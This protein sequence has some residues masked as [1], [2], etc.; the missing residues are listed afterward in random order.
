MFGRVVAVKST[1]NALSYNEQKLIAGRAECILAE[2]FV[3]D[4]AE[5]S[6]ED[7]LDHFMQWIS[8]N[9]RVEYNT[10][11]NSVNFG[12]EERI[13]NEQMQE[14]AKRYMEGIGFQDQPYLVYRHHDSAHPHF[15]TVST[16]IKPDGSPINIDKA[17]LH[18]SHELCRHLEKEFC[19][20]PRH[21]AGVEDEEKFRVD[22]A[23]RVVYGEKPLQRAISDVLHT[24]IDHYNYTNLA[25]L[26]A[27][28][29]LYGVKADRGRE[30]SRV[31]Q[32]RGLLYYAV[33]EDGR[34]MGK[35]IKASYF[36][37][38]PTLDNLEERFAINISQHQEHRQRMTTTIDWTLAGQPPDWQGFK[39]N[40]ESE[41][42][43]VVVQTD[44]KGRR[45]LFFVDHEDK[46]VYSGDSLGTEYGLE[47]LRSRCAAE[48]QLLEEETLYHR[49]HLRI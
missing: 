6:Q 27:A 10:L 36:L 3:K 35:S 21:R 17:T 4:L 34:Q 11:H 42:I 29:R 44:K 49:L 12:A 24:V 48:R 15:H 47:T 18:R 26:N 2:N 20:Q 5:L 38:K 9:E 37:L 19:L 41:G 25:E 46:S 40:L 33:D 22:H 39:D 32:N 23:Q 14:L 7:K 13:S 1:R 45:S 30:S 31:Y 28:L 8:L 16:F 43:D